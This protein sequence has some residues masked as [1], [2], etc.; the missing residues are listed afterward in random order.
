MPHT[1]IWVC[2]ALIV[3]LSC[4][5]A[6]RSRRFLG[7]GP[8]ITRYLALWFGLAL[9][10]ALTFMF[11]PG[12]QLPPWLVPAAIVILT[13]QFTLLL[14]WRTDLQA[15]LQ[16]ATLPDWYGLQTLRAPFGLVILTGGLLGLIPEPFAWAAGL[17]DV[18]VGL[19]ALLLRNF[20]LSDSSGRVAAWI[21]TAAGM[22]D[23]INAGRLGGALVV[24]WLAERQLPGFLPMLPFFGV[25]IFL[26]LHIQ[27]VLLL[28]RAARS[29][30]QRPA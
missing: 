3:L 16:S 22:A 1:L 10:V 24:P 5:L 27:T 8:F 18:A 12:Q 14:S 4:V 9:T 17:G 7:N 23:L 13:M 2:F 6:I 26:A 25:P 29:G 19:A 21:F 11:L 20:Q 30:R 15:H 28:L